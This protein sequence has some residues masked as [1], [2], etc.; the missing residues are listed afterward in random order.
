M[1][2]VILGWVFAAT[3]YTCLDVTLK[4]YTIY[5]SD[6]EYILYVGLLINVLMNYCILSV[7]RQ[8]NPWRSVRGIAD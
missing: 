1:K 4:V 8:R 7:L 5:G 6:N 2:G 3:F